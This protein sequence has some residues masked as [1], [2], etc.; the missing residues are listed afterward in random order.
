MR[1]DIPP[2]ARQNTK[3]KDALE[4]KPLNSYWQEARHLLSLYFTTELDGYA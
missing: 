4:R 2:I 1:I 3:S